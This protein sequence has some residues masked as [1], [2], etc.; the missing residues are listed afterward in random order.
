MPARRSGAA[1]RAA[2]RRRRGSAALPGGLL[3]GPGKSGRAAGAVASQQRPRVLHRQGARNGRGLAKRRLGLRWRH[4]VSGCCRSAISGCRGIGRDRAVRGSSR[5]PAAQ[6]TAPRRPT[7]PRARLPSR[8]QRPRPTTP[9][10]GDDTAGLAPSAD[11]SREPAAG[12]LAPRRPTMRMAPPRPI[13]PLC[14]RRWIGTSAGSRSSAELRR[15]GSN[16]R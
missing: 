5:A 2:V 3:E 15:G 7:T 16:R 10:P 14:K 6:A 9:S 11:S 12:A 4:A 1:H 8:G 13:R